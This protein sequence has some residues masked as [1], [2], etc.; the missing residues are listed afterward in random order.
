M[1]LIPPSFKGRRPVIEPDQIH[2]AAAHDLVSDVNA[3]LGLDV[4][5]LGD[6]SHYL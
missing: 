1:W 6:V 5:S 2:G 3:I 4:A